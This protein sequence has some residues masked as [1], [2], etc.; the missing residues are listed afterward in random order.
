MLTFSN[1]LEKSNIVFCLQGFSPDS[2]EFHSYNLNCLVPK[3]VCSIKIQLTAKCI[4]IR[5]SVKSFKYRSFSP[6]CCQIAFLS[7]S[8]SS[9]SSEMSCVTFAEGLSYVYSSSRGLVDQNVC[10][11]CE[12]SPWDSLAQG[13]GVADGVWRVQ[14]CLGCGLS[15]LDGWCRTNVHIFPSF[16]GCCCLLLKMPVSQNH[17]F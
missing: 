11:Q 7:S 9:P 16:M 3:V 4:P 12:I 10:L 8:C 2:S 1:V 14:D 15:G 13:G 6:V 5:G 17:L